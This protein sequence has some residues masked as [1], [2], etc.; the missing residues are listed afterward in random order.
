MKRLLILLATF[1]A[2][3]VAL[4]AAGWEPDV[5]GEDFEMRS[6]DQG[7]DYGGPV[8]S[9]LVRL[10][11]DTL[12][13][14]HRGV[15]YV[16]GFNDYFFQAD[17]A[18]RFDRHGY[19]FYA[20]DLRRYGRSLR[21]GRKAFEVRSFDEYTADIDSALAVMRVEGVREIV[22][23]GH[24]TGGLTAS[25]YL[26]RH[27]QPDIRALVLNSPFLDW[28]LGRMEC[29][30]PLVSFV[31]SFW[32]S[33][34]V[35]QG[36]SQAYAESLLKDYHGEWEY[37]TDWKFMRSPDVDAGWV[38]AVD[39]AQRALRDGHADIKVPI[40]LMYSARSTGGDTWNED[41]NDADAVLDPADIRRYGAGLGPHVTAVRVD[42]GLHDLV[43]SRSGVREPL[44][45]YI[46][47]WLARKL[48]D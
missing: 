38:R 42:G 11:A 46:F 6:F 33:L 10:R 3:F 17:M 36:M 31:G 34:R 1:A 14:R 28:N 30:V 8:C 35:P 24:S 5:L 15:L 45:R 9:T 2:S 7:T 43:L 26:S 47:A 22:L 12:D 25:Y 4:L 13:S 29:M 41:F 20:V 40:L 32:P 39:R 23:M 48:N 44:Y 19:E 16:H 37:D 18:R 27:P 21:K